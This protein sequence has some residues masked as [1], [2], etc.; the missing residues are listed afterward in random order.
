MSWIQWFLVAP[1]F[2]ALQYLHIWATWHNGIVCW[3]TF[4]NLFKSYAN[5]VM[6]L[7]CPMDYLYPTRVPN[8]LLVTISSTPRVNYKLD[9]STKSRS[10]HF[11]YNFY[12]YQILLNV[13]KNDYQKRIAQLSIPQ[14]MLRP[15][16][17][18]L[19][20]LLYTKKINKGYHNYDARELI[21]IW[22]TSSSSL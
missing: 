4:C 1:L 6:Y 11:A 10:L 19:Y 16:S 15:L 21:P 17:E 12:K 8:W 5:A 22:I 9:V 2:V 7:K 14:L 18:D 3:Y 13:L 20:S